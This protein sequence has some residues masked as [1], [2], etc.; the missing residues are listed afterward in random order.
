M[1]PHCFWLN[2]A[3]CLILGTSLAGCNAG[4]TATQAP[5]S[6]AVPTVPIGDKTGIYVTTTSATFA[7]NYN[8]IHVNSTANNNAMAICSSISVNTATTNLIVENSAASSSLLSSSAEK[9][10]HEL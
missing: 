1:K 10:E 9:E 7:S 4:S 3:V 6:I 8:V 5:N 2:A